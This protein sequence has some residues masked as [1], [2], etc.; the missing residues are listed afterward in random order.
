MKRAGHWLTG[1]GWQRHLATK[2]NLASQ[3]RDEKHSDSDFRVGMF[4]YFFQELDLAS[5]EFFANLFAGYD[6]KAFP[7]VR[8]AT[9][10]SK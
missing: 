9:S 1:S 10:R 6:E 7:T 8:D 4:F 3:E 2:L 5:G